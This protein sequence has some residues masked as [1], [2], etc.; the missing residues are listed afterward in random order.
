MGLFSR[1]FGG[2]KKP[3]AIE[4]V[5]AVEYKGFLIYQESLAESGQ[6]RIAGRITKEI[7]GELKSHR[8]IRS[9]VI[10]NKNDANELMLKKAQMFIDQM[11]ENIF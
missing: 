7:S 5:E 8:F 2:S 9:D 3:E 10:A 1:L 6:Y 4:Q 11:G